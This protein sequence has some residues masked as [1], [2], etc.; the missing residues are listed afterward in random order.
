MH[1]ARRSAL[2]SL[3]SLLAALIAVLAFGLAAFAA[4]ASAQQGD[5]IEECAAGPA[6]PY[7]SGAMLYEDFDKVMAHGQGFSCP[8]DRQDK[9]LTCRI[10]VKITVPA[11][12]A[13]YL[14]LGSRTL[15]DGVASR[16]VEHYKVGRR[17]QG[18]TY[19][20]PLPASV[21]SKL[22]A[23]R[24][25]AM[26]VAIHTTV[27]IPGKDK[28]YCPNEQSRTPPPRTS[29]SFDT[30]D[31]SGRTMIW[32]AGDGEIVCWNYMP[33]GAAIPTKWGA[34]CPRPVNVKW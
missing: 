9:S 24:I 16:V 26:G 3:R 34:R 6:A 23:K 30:D 21:K 28:F 22:K 31:E 10:D 11:K 20:L 27:T 12:V 15:V 14:R 32:G 29:C 1:S 5:C 17:D 4:T 8:E 33:W 18:R 13:S 25:Q 7:L 19:F 2:R